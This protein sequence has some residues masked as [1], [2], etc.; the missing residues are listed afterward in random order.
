[1]FY[2][3]R[4]YPRGCFELFALLFMDSMIRYQGYILPQ[5]SHLCETPNGHALGLY[6]TQ[7]EKA[8]QPSY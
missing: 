3:L 4:M 2:P 7:N 1:M 6:I 8:K 5:P